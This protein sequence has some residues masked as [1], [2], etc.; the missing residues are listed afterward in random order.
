MPAHTTR[1]QPR[2]KVNGAFVPAHSRPAH[3][4]LWMQQLAPR[5]SRQPRKRAVNEDAARRRSLTR[6]I[7]IWQ[8]HGLVEQGINQVKAELAAIQSQFI[9]DDTHPLLR[10]RPALNGETDVNSEM[11]WHGLCL[12]CVGT[13]L[14]AS[15]MAGG[16]LHKGRD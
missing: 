11:Y 13:R 12:L 4:L 15:S 16:R 7:G 1:A 5:I 8:H 2:R 3:S 6:R 9:P 14:I 10:L